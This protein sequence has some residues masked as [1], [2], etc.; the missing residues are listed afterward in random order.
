MSFG[1]CADAGSFPKELRVVR[2]GGVFCGETGFQFW[3]IK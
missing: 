3:L 1:T 2:K